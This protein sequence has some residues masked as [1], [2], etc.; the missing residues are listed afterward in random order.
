[1]RKPDGHEGI[2]SIEHSC[3]PALPC[4][5]GALSWPPACTMPER[6]MPRDLKTVLIL[7][8]D[9]ATAAAWAVVVLVKTVL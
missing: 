7:L 2:Y 8:L 3:Q 9:V 4:S 5:R 6:L 1:M